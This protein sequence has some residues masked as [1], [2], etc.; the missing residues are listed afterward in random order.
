MEITVE[1]GPARVLAAGQ[2]TCFHGHPL[3]LAIDLGDSTFAV[4]LVF[5]SATPGE[6]PRVETRVVADGLSFYLTG[7][8]GA[9]GRGS[10]Q[11]VLLAEDGE[12]LIFLHFR[13]FRYGR[14]E[15]RT[16]HYTFYRVAKDAVAWRPTGGSQP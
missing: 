15:D 3:R 7:F 10:S 9:E 11:P 14:S 13:V 8:D 2:V 12:D 5:T 6:G 16:V 4:D 1:S